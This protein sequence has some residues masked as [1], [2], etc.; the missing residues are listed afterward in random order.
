MSGTPAETRQSAS[1]Q[2][3]WYRRLSLWRAIAGMAITVGVACVI[4]TLELFSEFYHQRYYYH[5]RLLYFSSQL[6]RMRSEIA[7]ADRQ[8]AEVRREDNDRELMS[9]I[10]AARDVRLI[11]FQALSAVSQHDGVMPPSGFVVSSEAVHAAV[12]E[13]NKLSRARDGAT[14]ELWWKLPRH[15]AIKG[16]SFETDARGHAIVALRLPARD[17]AINGAFVS[18][19]SSAG[20]VRPNGEIMLKGEEVEL[21]PVRASPR[22]A[23]PSSR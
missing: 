6:R 8:I 5:H 17:Q 3:P 16:G 4:I 15:A 9:R 14:Y 2:T 13:V 1:V 21:T 23:T 11:R 22:R 12:L 18:L 20:S 10:L 19:Q 7:R